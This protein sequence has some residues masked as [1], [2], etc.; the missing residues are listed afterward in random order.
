MAEIALKGQ[1]KV[2][3]LKAEF[4]EA[5]GSTLR[6]YKSVT[7]K[8]A[9]ADDEATLASIRAEGA[10]GGELSVKGNMHVGNFEKKIA[11]MYGIGVQVANVDNTKLVQNDLTLASLG[12]KQEAAKTINK[13]EESAC[14]MK[15]RIELSVNGWDTRLFLLDQEHVDEALNSGDSLKK[16][17]RN[18]VENWDDPIDPDFERYYITSESDDFIL[19]IK[20][21]NGE[22]IYE[23]NDV[24]DYIS[25][26]KTQIE[27]EDGYLTDID[28]YE[29]VGI[30]DGMYLV[31]IASNE[32]C[33]G[34]AEI[35]LDHPFNPDRLYIV[36]SSHV[37]DE[38]MDDT[39]YE[40]FQLYYQRG[41][42]FDLKR[43]LIEL[44]NNGWDDETYASYNLLK[45]SDKNYWQ[46]IEE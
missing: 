3:T 4:K 18:Y 5:F 16:F 31:R 21:E 17:Y 15:Y 26:D 28:G 12:N 22:T 6:V 44:L 37:D 46:E 29:F 36:R 27:D 30:K 43:D 33:G 7:C 8:G 20:D 1:M 14:C 35:E 38:L 40:M 9:F 24:D 42:G 10:K 41:E 32:N 45:V 2:K 34:Y 25:N 39:V 19:E 11:D 13:S 23:L